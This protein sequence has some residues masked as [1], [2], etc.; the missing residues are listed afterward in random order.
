MHQVKKE[1]GWLK[2]KSQ[3]YVIIPV[4]A[5]TGRW[6]GRLPISHI[7]G[8]HYENTPIQ[9]YC[10]FYHQKMKIFR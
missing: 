4:K 6:V 8:S 1:M 5:Y 10:K 2:K 7:P 3:V 9:I